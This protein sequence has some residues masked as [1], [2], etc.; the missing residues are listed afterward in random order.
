MENVL[1][2]FATHY[3]RH[4]LS[5]NSVRRVAIYLSLL[6]PSRSPRGASTRPSSKDILHPRWW[7]IALGRYTIKEQQ[8]RKQRML[9]VPQ[10]TFAQFLTVFGLLNTKRTAKIAF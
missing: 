7:Y 1:L 8:D 10:L 9:N 6:R 2:R 4:S 3:Y 5:L